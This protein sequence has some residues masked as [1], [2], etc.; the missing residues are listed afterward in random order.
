MNDLMNIYLTL[1]KTP[2]ERMWTSLY[3]YLLFYLAGLGLS[4]GTWVILLHHNLWDLLSR[5]ISHCSAPASL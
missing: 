2:E 1:S 5:G 4:G 3:S